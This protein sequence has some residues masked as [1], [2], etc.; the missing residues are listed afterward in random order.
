MSI[1]S[2]DIKA[3]YAITD[4]SSWHIWIHDPNYIAKSFQLTSLDNGSA[5]EMWYLM[6]LSEE[7]DED[8]VLTGGEVKVIWRGEKGLIND[9]TLEHQPIFLLEFEDGWALF[10]PGL[11]DKYKKVYDSLRNKN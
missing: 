9:D 2:N 1:W 4:S 3:K 8:E 5:S 10:H 6:D 7:P 11:Y